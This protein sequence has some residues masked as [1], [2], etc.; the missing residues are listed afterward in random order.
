MKTINKFELEGISSTSENSSKTEQTQQKGSSNNPFKVLEFEDLLATNTWQGGYV[1]GIGFVPKESNNSIFSSGYDSYGDG[2]DFDF[3][4]YGTENYP[5]G[6]K[7]SGSERAKIDK[8]DCSYRCIGLILGISSLTI[9]DVYGDWLKETQGV[10]TK[11]VND[12]IENG[13]RLSDM[14][15]FL[16]DIS[17]KVGY[18][19][20]KTYARNLISE[21]KNKTDSSYM[22]IMKT[23][24]S[25]A[26]HAIRIKSI[27]NLANLDPVNTEDWRIQDAV[28][29]YYDPQN[30]KDDTTVLGHLSDIY[31]FDKMER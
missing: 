15:N 31:A 27:D 29:H 26:K 4:D 14:T 22:G 21:F 5:N 3:D 18:K 13:L 30:N 17:P 11:D 28:V 9:S 24:N 16:K 7:Y 2:F 8:T 10:D 23:D 12:M 25:T 6:Y 1:E 20:R 19:S